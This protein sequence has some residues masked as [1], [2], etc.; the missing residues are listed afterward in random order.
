M[1]AYT[2]QSVSRIV[3]T[4]AVDGRVILKDSNNSSFDFITSQELTP[5]E[6]PQ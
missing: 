1:P 3:D 6:V 4:V 2:T 5:G